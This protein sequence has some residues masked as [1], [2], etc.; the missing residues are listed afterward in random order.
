MANI[1]S[2]K[3]VGSDFQGE[4][5][6]LSLQTKGVASCPRPTLQRQRPQPRVYVVGRD[7]GRLVEAFQRGPDYLSLKL[8]DPSFN[9]PISPTSSTTRTARA[10]PS[11]GRAQQAQRRLSQPICNAPPVP[12]AGFCA[13]PFGQPQVILRAADP[14]LRR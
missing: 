9:A 4:I 7:R 14:F 10:T 13:K 11:S 3:K 6:T 12:R 1:G 5:V 2:F 8:D